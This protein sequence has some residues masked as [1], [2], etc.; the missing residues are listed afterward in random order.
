MTQK[1]SL[2]ILAALLAVG[3]A[4]NAQPA[5]TSASTPPFISAG[6]VKIAKQWTIGKQP[7]PML[8]APPNFS[9]IRGQAFITVAWGFTISTRPK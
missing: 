5:S 4:A 7:P 1:P 2:F 3:S 6:E 8:M 9:D